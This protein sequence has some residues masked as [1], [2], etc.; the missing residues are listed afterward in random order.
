MVPETV[1]TICI[2]TFRRP[3]I[4]LTLGSLS[5][6]KTD[7]SWNVN[8]IVADNDFTPSARELVEA[9]A[10]GFPFPIRYIH[11]PASNISI[12]RNAC[13]GAAKGDYLAFIDDDETVTTDWLIELMNVATKNNAHAVLGPVRA[14]FSKDSPNWMVQGNFHS[15]F[16]TFVNG[17]IITGYTCNSLLDMRQP[18]L[19]E[20]RFDIGRGKSGGEDTD[21]FDRIYSNGGRISYAE[22]AWVEEIVPSSR[23]SLKW[24]ATRR[25]RSGQTHGKILLKKKKQAIARAYAFL[26]TSFKAAYCFSGAALTVFSPVSWRRN[27]IRGA[28]HIGVLSALV[29]AQEIE[30]YG[31]TLTDGK[32]TNAR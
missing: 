20:L 24:L 11:A 16:P 18:T 28:L 9:S 22:N 2:C 7:K 25:Y 23:A 6:I 14:I 10:V 8:V 21:F 26:I 3:Q 29:G 30:Q 5:G 32:N 17:E 15:T 13:L 31:A 4:T 12:A 27:Y 1:I 19:S